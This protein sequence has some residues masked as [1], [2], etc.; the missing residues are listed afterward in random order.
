MTLSFS[1]TPRDHAA[2]P[3]LYNYAIFNAL[4]LLLANNHQHFRELV[5]DLNETADPSRW[6]ELPRS[7]PQSEDR[8]R[9]QTVDENTVCV[10]ESRD[11]PAYPV[12]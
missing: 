2:E 4:D 1:P 10:K 6:I 5:V 8:I 3:A 11:G 9:L 12:C 7:S